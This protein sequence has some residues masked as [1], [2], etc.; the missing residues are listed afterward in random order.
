MAPL[1][2]TVSTRPPSRRR[3]L[4]ATLGRARRKAAVATGVALLAAGAGVATTSTPVVL[5][6]PNVSA[7]EATAEHA[8]P[9]PATL[10][11]PVP[12]ETPITTVSHTAEGG[13]DPGSSPGQAL[14]GGTAS[15][16]GAELA[17]NPTANGE[18]FDPSELTAAHRTLPFGTRVRVTNPGNGESV[19]VRINDRGPFHGDRVIDVSTA[20]AK[21]IG[22]KQAGTLE[23]DLE[24][25]PAVRG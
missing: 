3:R 14:E 1:V 18:T 13:T 7:L 22:L 12:A 15:Y 4:R 17:G 5:D 24:R 23:V 11:P 19:V 25:L 20:A 16:Y 2:S 8:T 10:L 6:A 21:E 9:P